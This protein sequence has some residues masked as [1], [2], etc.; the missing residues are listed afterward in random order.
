MSTDSFREMKG[1]TELA[2]EGQLA[3]SSTAGQTSDAGASSAAA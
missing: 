3:R 2:A 1:A